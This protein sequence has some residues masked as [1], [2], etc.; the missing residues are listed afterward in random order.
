MAS[1]E[2]EL[3]ATL[4]AV[5]QTGSFT[6][7]AARLGIRQ[8]TVS[9]HV[10]RLE[11]KAG[12]LLV[13]RDTHSVNL[14]A[15][16]EAM[17]GFARTILSA[18]EQAAAYFSGSKP[19]GRLRI[20]M[21][22]DLALTRLPQ[23]L[24]DFRRDN[25]A[26]D[27]D[28]TVDQ[29]G[30]LHQRLESDRLDVFIGKRPRGEERG[31][32]VKRDRLVW[33]G[34][35]NTR[36]DLS[37]PIPLVLYPAPSVSRTEMHRALSRAGLPY[38]SACTVNGVNGLIAGVAAGIGVSALAASLVPAQLTTLGAGHRLPEL[39]SID[40]LLLTNPRTA[41]RPAVRALTATVLASG[42]QSIDR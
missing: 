22:D 11:E 17:A 9:Q 13:Q 10:R 5:E 25:P 18:H 37:K 32:L 6:Q 20:G 4:L 2:P 38:R 30:L 27:F 19:R 33:V 7:A 15:D 31:Q 28:L 21:S 8:P 24:R 39:G 29:S 42:R 34:T 16:G 14:T 41:Q 3:L 1:F 23:I 35:P 26:V 40:L 12:R 36:L